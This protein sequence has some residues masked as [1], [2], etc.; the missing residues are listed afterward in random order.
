MNSS[1]KYSLF[2]TIQTK[3]NQKSKDK[4]ESPNFS[5]IIKEI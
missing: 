5:Q 3:I 4:I 2:K 1:F